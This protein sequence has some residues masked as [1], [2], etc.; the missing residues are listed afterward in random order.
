[1]GAFGWGSE[2]AV[3]DWLFEEG[4]RFDFFQAVRLIEKMFPEAAR[5]GETAE[6]HREA[7]RF[8][9]LADLAFPAADVG[10]IARAG[11]GDGAAGPPVTMRVNFMGLAGHLGPLPEPYTEALLEQ[12]THR[13]ARG[14]RITAFRDFL[15]IFNH[16]LVSLLYRVRKQ[17]HIGL[18]LRPPEQSHAAQYLYA[19]MGLATPGLRGRMAVEDRVLLSYAGLLSQKPRSAAGLETLLRHHFGVPV[20]LE[21]FVGRWR[22]LSDD[23]LTRIAAPGAAAGRRAGV[24]A[25][26]RPAGRPAQNNRL[27]RDAVLGSRVWQQASRFALHLGPL[28]LPDFLD[29]LPGGTAHRALGELTRFYVN[30]DAAFRFVLR[31]APGEVPPARLGSVLGPRLGWTSWLAPHPPDPGATTPFEVTVGPDFLAP[32]LQKLRIPLFAELPRAAYRD[33]Y[34]AMEPLRLPEGKVIARRG[35]PAEAFYVIHAGSVRVLRDEPGRDEG[36]LA[37]LSEGHCFGGTTFAPG[38]QHPTTFVTAEPCEILALT[39]ARLQAV[40]ERHPAVHWAVD[41]YRR[42]QQPEDARRNDPHAQLA[43][44]LRTLDAPLL[45]DFTEEGLYEIAAHAVLEAVPPGTV[46]ARQGTRGDALLVLLDGT[47]QAV[48]RRPDGPPAEATLAPGAS[49][50][51]RTLFLDAPYGATVTTLEPA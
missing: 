16:R 45:R 21:Q 30:Q 20:R 9:S 26:L 2:R 3:G 13:D 12:E 4:Y 31:L 5:L 48:T 8:T 25:P 23:Q 50:G 42:K 17:H 51:A 40:C 36:V 1:M 27:G 14:E 15:D 38:K 47:A 19:L 34:E 37:T 24:R 7:V 6:P 33:V 11:A 39:H 49:I 32:E 44:R 10:G 46:L 28:A 22:G 41:A 35:D 18:D 43:R 29:F